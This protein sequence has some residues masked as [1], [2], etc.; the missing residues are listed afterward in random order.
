M[1]V[2]HESLWQKS[3]VLM[4]RA[5]EARDQLRDDDYQL[6]AALHLEVLGKARLARLHPSLRRSSEVT[7]LCS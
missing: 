5:L 3:K 2:D 4:D 6:W 7:R 1:A